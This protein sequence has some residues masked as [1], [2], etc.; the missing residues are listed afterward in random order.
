[1]ENRRL[2]LLGTLLVGALAL[3]L[4]GCGP[5]AIKPKS[6][7]DTPQNHFNQ[8]MRE[9]DRGNLDLAMQEFE[10]AKALDPK[11]AEAYAGMALVHA[12]KQDF[13]KAMELADQALSKN[14]NSLDA[15]I[16]KGR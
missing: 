3:W 4:V 14:K 13:V 7:L 12:S 1:M 6:V 2:M 9:L 15:R 10:R 8:G 5:K 11:Y 16:I